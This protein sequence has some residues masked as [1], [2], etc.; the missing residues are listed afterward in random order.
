MHVALGGSSLVEYKLST[1]KALNLIPSIA[2]KKKKKKRERKS[3]EIPI[4][5]TVVK[6]RKHN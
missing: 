4:N 6:F 1:Y 3:M 2:K 5:F